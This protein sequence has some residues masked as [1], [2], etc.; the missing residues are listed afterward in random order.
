MITLIR[1][2]EQQLVSTMLAQDRVAV[3]M[4]DIF[5]GTLS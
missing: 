5:I 2:L 1:M 3:V 4:E